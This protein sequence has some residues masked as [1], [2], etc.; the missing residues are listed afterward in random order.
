MNPEIIL[1]GLDKLVYQE[2]GSMSHGGLPVIYMEI[3]SVLILAYMLKISLIPTKIPATFSGGRLTTWI[4]P[5]LNQLF[6]NKAF[7]IVLK[8][9]TVAVFLLI[10]IAGLFGTPI[11]ERNAATVLTWGLWWSSII[12]FS[13][14]FGSIWCSVCP[15]DT[16]ASWLTKFSIWKKPGRT[17]SLNR[18]V[19][20]SIRNLSVATVL[21]IV[22]SWFELAWGITTSPYATALLAFVF[23][24]LATVS[25]IV[26]ERKAFCQYFCP[27]GRTI[28]IYSKLSA[29]KIKA[30]DPSICQQCET[31]ECYHGDQTYEACPTHLT[32]GLAKDTNYCISCGNCV[33]SCPDKN[34]AWQNHSVQTELIQHSK[35]NGSESWF[36]ISLF[37]LTLF[38]GVTMLPFWEN[39]V[40]SL[41]VMIGDSGKLLWSFS[42]LMAAFYGLIALLFIISA[43]LTAGLINNKLSLM[44][45]FNPDQKTRRII[46]TLSLALLPLALTYHL[47]HNSMHLL[48][49]TSGL[50]EVF[51]NPLGNA[52]LPL[53][54]HEIHQRHNSF[55]ANSTLLHVFQTALLTTGT[56]L[57]FK[58]LRIKI[59]QMQTPESGRPRY[60]LPMYLLVFL[61]AT[62]C[63]LMLIQPMVMRN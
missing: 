48:L 13:L 45:F 26:F 15:W 14:L 7:L 44:Q 1:F 39:S 63:F 9:I 25:I 20:A 40:S 24:F 5:I 12:F 4:P 11:P 53:S 58:L 38:H 54:M 10:L 52:A 30:I 35:I 55:F 62:F 6:N 2:A 51:L 8:L 27:I 57:A 33:Y 29:T 17:Y 60:T 61:F 16:L 59:G 34:L 37:A 19:P 23:L 46:H 49:E 42:I 3:A 31:L 22:L 32:L 18:V 43:R 41:A 56:L 36:L 47:A 28:G 21:F 50:G